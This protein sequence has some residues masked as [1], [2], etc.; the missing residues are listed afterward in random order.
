MLLVTTG[1][2]ALMIVFLVHAVTHYVVERFIHWPPLCHL[3]MVVAGIACFFGR[4]MH[5]AFIGIAV[6]FIG[7]IWV[8]FYHRKFGKRSSAAHEQSRA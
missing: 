1:V 8:D 5:F 4:N 6:L 7:P 3:A 2:L